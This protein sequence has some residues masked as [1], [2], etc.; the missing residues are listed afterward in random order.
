[1]SN[2]LKVMATP[3]A[4]TVINASESDDYTIDEYDI[5]AGLELI[6]PAYQDAKVN[7]TVRVI[8]GDARSEE[9]P[10]TALDQL[11]MN[12]D[13]LNDYPPECHADGVYDVY[14]IVLDEYQNENPSA[15]LTLTIAAGEHVGTL[16]APEVPDAAPGY[17]NYNAAEDDVEVD[18]TY[19]PMNAGDSITLTVQ[20]YDK[21]TDQQKFNKDYPAYTVTAADVAV[22]SVKMLNTVTLADMQVI[23]EE[24]YALFW[25]TVTPADGSAVETSVTFKTIVDVIPPGSM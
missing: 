13:I 25:Y 18:I 22:G 6:I 20:G 1:M 17:I 15:H 2:K 14:Y 12:I 21:D 11:P 5:K 7:D 10:V 16:P 23:G 3:A 9:Y 24:A 19:A 8:W 4:P